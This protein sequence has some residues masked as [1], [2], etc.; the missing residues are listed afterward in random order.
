MVLHNGPSTILPPSD[1]FWG[2]SNGN[3]GNSMN[4]DL[5]LPNQPWLSNFAEFALQVQDIPE[6]G[7]LLLASA[8]MLAFLL[9]RG[10]K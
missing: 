6:P 9:A 8:G 7:S 10:R 4:Q 5:S 1:F 2:W 3:A